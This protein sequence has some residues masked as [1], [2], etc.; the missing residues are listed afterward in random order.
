MLSQ[1]L[2]QKQGSKSVVEYEAEF[3]RLIK[4]STE[5]IRDHE[6]TKVQK[7]RDGL[8]PE[9][10][11]DMQGFELTTLGA[12]VNKAKAIEESRKDMKTEK[13]SKKATLGKR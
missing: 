7:F 5:G 9:L 2:T 13:D 12:M 1:L 3:N 4:F 10:R 8:T 11:H 6:M